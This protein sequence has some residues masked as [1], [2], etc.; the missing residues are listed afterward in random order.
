[1]PFMIESFEV[2][3]WSDSST[4]MD[5]FTPGIDV[6]TTL[7]VPR[8]MAAESRRKTGRPG[9]CCVIKSGTGPGFVRIYGR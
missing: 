8:D 7:A 9:T 5:V 6:V 4:G 1:M 2:K 3:V